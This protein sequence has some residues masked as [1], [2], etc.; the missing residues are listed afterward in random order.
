[1][2]AKKKRKAYRVE[3]RCWVVG[4]SCGCIIPG[5]RDRLGAYWDGKATIT[6]DQAAALLIAEQ[7]AEAFEQPPDGSVNL[8][9]AFVNGSGKNVAYRRPGSPNK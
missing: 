8:P 3:A 7:L 2:A 6:V 4:C 5:R 1:M 9:S